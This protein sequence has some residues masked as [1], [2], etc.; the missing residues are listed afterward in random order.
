M[1]ARTATGVILGMLAVWCIVSN[2]CRLLA[3]EAEPAEEGAPSKTDLKNP[4]KA[5]T[6]GPEA[7]AAEPTSQP[8]ANGSR[9]KPQATGN[10]GLPAD[11][12]P[13]ASA[14]AS[15]A[16]DCNGPLGLGETALFCGE[17]FCGPPGRFWLRTDLLA[18]WTS[19]MRLPPLVTTG[20]LDGTSTILFGNE[21]VN[22]GARPGYRVTLG[23]W[24]NCGR[25][26]GL[27]ADFFDL[28]G[29]GTNYY[30]ASD[31]NGS[32]PLFR[33]YFDVNPADGGA[34]RPAAEIISSPNVARGDVT[35]NATDYFRSAGFHLRTAL[36]CGDPCCGSPCGC[37]ESCGSCEAIARCCRVDLIAGWR[38]CRLSDSVAINENVTGLPGSSIQY[39]TFTVADSFQAINE[40]HGA[41]IGL[42][43]QT[44][45]GPW[46]L[47]LMTK[48]AFGNNHMVAHLDGST[49]V[50]QRNSQGQVIAQQL[51]PN[52]GV[53]VLNTN[54]GAYSR[55]EFVVI[56]QFGLE[57][58]YQVTCRLRAYL[59][60]NF[61]YWACV[62]RA[63]D[64][65]D[66][67]IDSARIP[68]PDPTHT[69]KEPFPAFDFHGTNF[70]AHG[71]NGGVELRY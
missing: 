70:W 7:E 20:P 34:T 12:E 46:S 9:A 27:E 36:C 10:G 45:R 59:G 28:G 18:W 39:T 63:G 40:F 42:I 22:N 49:L 5:E 44:H 17:C 71:I 50:T 68:P 43:A 57:V 69:P 4:F 51:Y 21:T 55:D 65:I 67:N 1:A 25:T 6:A 56:P 61:L 19:G 58:G 14:P 29:T 11:R 62:A 13:G 8:K 60:Y 33:P 41:E 38:Y 15:P 26:W 31:P 48:M 66:Q 32:P 35:V 52:Q 47:E 30:A 2:D 64:Q 54:Q 37:D 3:A 23:Y 24:L 16:T 53:Y